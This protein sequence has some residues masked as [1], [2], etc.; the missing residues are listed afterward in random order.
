MNRQ[1]IEDFVNKDDR[2]NLIFTVAEMTYWYHIAPEIKEWKRLEYTGIG[3]KNPNTHK[4]FAVFT[5]VPGKMI[6]ID[7]EKLF[8]ILLL[9]FQ[10]DEAEDFVASTEKM[11]PP[12]F[13]SRREWYC[14]NLEDKDIDYVFTLGLLEHSLGQSSRR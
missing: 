13:F 14:L 4:W 7:S 1:I 11:L 3:L 6:G 12:V 9:R 10:K 5:R 2:I 8:R